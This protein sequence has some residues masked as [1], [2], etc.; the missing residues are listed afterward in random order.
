MN[1]IKIILFPVFLFLFVQFVPEAQAAPK[2]DPR[3]YINRT[4]FK[5]DYMEINYEITNAGFVELH[6]FDP[7][8]K[9]IWIKGKVTDRIGV[10][11]IRIP[12]KPLKPGERY[13]FIL[14]YKGKEYSGNF[15]TD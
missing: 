14:K 7:S 8:G 3:L 6:L 2:E 9:K 13:S 10:D 12:K 1:T 15:Y 11:L 4:D 5:G